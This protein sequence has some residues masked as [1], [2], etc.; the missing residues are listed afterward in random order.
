MSNL[1]STWKE[2]DVGGLYCWGGG[3]GN[4]GVKELLRDWKGGIEGWGEGVKSIM[5]G[6]GGGRE[7]EW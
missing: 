3:W 1:V 4:L 7:Y 6:E 5:K 2:G